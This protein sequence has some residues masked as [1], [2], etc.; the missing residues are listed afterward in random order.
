MNNHRRYWL[1]Q[2]LLTALSFCST[3]SVSS[4]ADTHNFC[5]RKIS[6]SSLQEHTSQS[7]RITPSLH[8]A[9]LWIDAF[10]EKPDNLYPVFTDFLVMLNELTQNPHHRSIAIKA[11]RLITRHLKKAAN[12]LE[13]IF[14]DPI[15][16]Y[17]SFVS[18]IGI[19]EK[20]QESK[21]SYVAYFNRQATMPVELQYIPGFDQAIA[22]H[23]IDIVGDYLIDISFLDWIK[24]RNPDTD[25][26][27]PTG[28]LQPYL[29]QV[30]N[31]ELFNKQP[32]SRSAE[33]DMGYFVTHLAFVLT[34]YGERPFPASNHWRQL[35]RNYLDK[36]T[37]VVANKLN[38]I[39]LLGEFLHC[40]KY[41]SVVNTATH[42]LENFLLDT[43][44]QDGSWGNVSDN[45]LSTY[46]RL[47]PTWSV[48]TAL[49]YPKPAVGH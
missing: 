47:H 46:D 48:A 5:G 15:H 8:K 7:N 33:S 31:S 41:L 16:S 42:E 19:V 39:D 13:E 2:G 30:L 40:Y 10:G 49:N 43:Q 44:N 22:N 35:I 18:L 4:S 45:S 6:R 11:E 20:Y 36:N 34:H 12:N 21:Q 28:N 14:G 29:D 23:N 25:F 1:S 32:S 37:C 38:D 27:L 24:Q 26:H 9:L 17:W 3:A